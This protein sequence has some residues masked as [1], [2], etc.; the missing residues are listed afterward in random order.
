MNNNKERA[1]EV[2]KILFSRYYRQRRS[3]YKKPEPD[4][5]EYKEIYDKILKSI[6]AGKKINLVLGYGHH[7]NINVCGTV[8]PDSAEILS[9][10][11]LTELAKKIQSVYSVGAEITLVTTG[12][13]AEFANGSELDDIAKYHELMTK[14]IE[15]DKD[16][17]KI[18]RLTMLCD[19]W[20]KYENFY[21]TVDK[22]INIIQKEGIDPEKLNDLIKRAK[23]NAK[24]F[25]SN[26]EALKSVIRFQATFRAENEL[27]V[28]SESFP[29]SIMCSY[30]INH[31]I[32]SYVLLNT[33][34]KG[35]I[36]QPWE[37]FCGNGDE[38]RTKICF[39]RTLSI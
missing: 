24:G 37:G 20:K 29:N 32:G 25:I 33:V 16:F 14:L 1:T 21:P 3:G 38:I 18:F 13:R 8:E 5:L 39:V 9:L 10:N 34:K 6:E 22:K 27:E 30:R 7:K 23:R 15:S 35:S 36:V 12:A 17:S 19:I 28:W 2:I 11:F 31:F 4:S 26:E